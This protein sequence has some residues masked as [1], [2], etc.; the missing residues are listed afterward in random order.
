MNKE[1]KRTL[2]ED[3]KNDY[4]R[5]LVKCNEQQRAHHTRVVPDLLQ[6]Y[7]AEYIKSAETYCQTV[8]KYCAAE[9]KF[10]PLMSSC[11]GDISAKANQVNGQTDAD[12]VVDE[13]K[14]G[15]HPPEDIPFEG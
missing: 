11:L 2:A 8:K 1:Q 4:A 15:Y 13:F 14:T 6:Q 10:R 9:E 12:S 5:A 7:Q 3:A